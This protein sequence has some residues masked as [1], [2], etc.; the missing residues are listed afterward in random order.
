[1]IRILKNNP[2][3]PSLGFLRV[4]WPGAT[5]MPETRALYMLRPREKIRK[6]KSRDFSG[7]R[8]PVY[9]SIFSLHSGAAFFAALASFAVWYDAVPTRTF[10]II[11]LARNLALRGLGILHPVKFLSFFFDLPL[12][13]SG[14]N[15]FE[16][17]C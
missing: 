11:F 15:R 13:A 4:Y 17:A 16:L 6:F 14:T 8:R 5:P 3:E 7:E 9:F 10:A 1:V 12:G 2:K